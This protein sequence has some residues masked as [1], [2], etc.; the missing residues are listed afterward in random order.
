[1]G[2]LPKKS[3]LFSGLFSQVVVLYSNVLMCMFSFSF[4]F[5][6]RVRVQL[7]LSL[8]LL[9]AGGRIWVHKSKRHSCIIGMTF[10]GS[11]GY[12]GSGIDGYE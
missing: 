3:F 6:S 8:L 1:M 12:E 11:V 10:V 2:W 5:S 9:V 4:P 7:W